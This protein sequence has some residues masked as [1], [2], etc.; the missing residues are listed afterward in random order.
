[1]N[2]STPRIRLLVAA[3]LLVSVGATAC[4]SPPAVSSGDPAAPL[5]VRVAAVAATTVTD[6]S[7]AGGVVQARTTATVA[8]RVLGPVL[9]VHVAPGDR[10]R[11]GQVLVVLDGRDLEAGARSATAAAAQARSGASAADAD[12]RAAQAGLVLARATHGRIAQL[13]AKRSATAQELDEATAALA[14]AEARAAS[15]AARQQEAASGIERAAAASDAAGA[16]ASFL[17]ITAPFA[18]V[19]TEKMVEPGNMATPGLPLVRLED[20]RGFR[21]DVRVD[22]SRAARIATGAA[23]EVVLD[24]AD[25]Q[26]TVLPGVVSEVSRA[27]DAEARTFLVKITLPDSEG[28]RSGGFGRAR[29]ADGTRDALTVPAEAVVQQGQVSAV[30]VADNGVARLRLVRVRGTEVQA[31]LSAGELVVVAPPPGLTDGR[32][33]TTGGAR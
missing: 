13:H 18:G 19:V 17:R 16:T 20:T 33:I 28:L 10:V 4:T 8:A 9:S 11:A 15:A 22:E 2:D 26:P 14:A 29:F 5:A 30:F 21:L 3:L 25:G 1:M 31:G 7:E 27:L 32:R 24:G 12:A 6:V 23:V